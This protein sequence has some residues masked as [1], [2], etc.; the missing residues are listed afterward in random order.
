MTES[1]QAERRS[2]IFRQADFVTNCHSYSR[3]ECPE[4]LAQLGQ[5][6]RQVLTIFMCKNSGSRLVFRRYRLTVVEQYESC[7]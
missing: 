1:S 7:G 3:R 5:A 6:G 4:E 2:D